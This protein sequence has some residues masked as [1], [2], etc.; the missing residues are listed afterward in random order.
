MF[1]YLFA[2]TLLQTIGLM[3]L[4]LTLKPHKHSKKIQ[5]MNQ[6]MVK[7]RQSQGVIPSKTG[8]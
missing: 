7:N 8:V 1:D 5:I 2:L 4:T 6:Y 3:I